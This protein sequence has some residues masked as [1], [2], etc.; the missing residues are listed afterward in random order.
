MKEIGEKTTKVACGIHHILAPY[1]E[2][3]LKSLGPAVLTYKRSRTLLSHLAEI[4]QRSTSAF[5]EAVNSVHLNG[6]RRAA[7]RDIILHVRSGSSASRRQRT[8]CT[9]RVP[10]P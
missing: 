3:T 4:S 5:A 6:G 2:F 9:L 7:R 10:R 8:S 1:F